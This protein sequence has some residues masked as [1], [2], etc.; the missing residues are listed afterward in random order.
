MEPK[1]TSYDDRQSARIIRRALELQKDEG[2]AGH[3]HA[4]L[5]LEDLEAIGRES[6][7]GPDFIRRAALELASEEP[8][9]G[10]RLARSF[11]GHP[12]RSKTTVPSARAA[13]ATLEE[14]LVSLASITGDMGSGSIVGQTLT[15]NSDAAIAVRSGRSLSVIVRPAS[16]GTEVC[17]ES[18]IGGTA[19]GL[20]GGL[21]GGLGLGAGLGVGMGIGIGLLGS[22]AFTLVVPIG[23]LAASWL[24]AR[25]IFSLVFRHRRRRDGRI[26]ERIRQL[27][28][29]E[30]TVGQ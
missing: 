17:V 1:D 15:W 10:A 3:G 23:F 28:D 4:G 19:G 21:M 12:I 11:L 30:V 20:F 27:L 6:G 25:G 26:A 16:S 24:L 18:N 14:L 7:I 8:N 2:A 13:K 9:G 5:S 22:L 29:R